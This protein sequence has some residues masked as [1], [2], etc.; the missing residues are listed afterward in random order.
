MLH[1][2]QEQRR[3]LNRLDA[4]NKI[5]EEARQT[6]QTF[7]ANVSHELRTPLN[8][9]IAYSDLITQSPHIYGR[10]PAPLLAD[11]AVIQRNGQHLSRLIDDVLD[12]SQIETGRMALSKEW[13]N[14][15][16][17]VREATETVKPLY[18]LKDLQLTFEVVD[19]LPK[20]FCDRTRIRQVLI[21][22]LS[23]AGRFTEDGGVNIRAWLA[24]SKIMI[25]ITDTGPG[26]S[27]EV[28]ENLF[29]PFQQLDSSFRRK[30]GGSGLG[31]NISKHFIEMH[32]G[33]VWLESNPGQGSTF[34]V[35]LPIDLRP[36]NP[37]ET[38]SDRRWVSPFHEYHPRTRRRVAKLPQVSPRYVVLD[39]ANTLQRLLSRYMENIDVVSTHSVP[40]A[41]E[42]LSETP[43]FAFIVNSASLQKED[44]IAAIP[45]VLPFDT[46]FVS[47]WLTSHDSIDQ[48]DIVQYIVK[49]VDNTALLSAVRAL[50]DPVRT[51][52][53]ADDEPDLLRLFTRLLTGTPEKY[54][55]IGA[56]NGSE[57]LMLLQQSQ[58]D[59]LILDLIMPNMS[60]FDLLKAKAS[61]AAIRDIPVIV[62]SSRDPNSQPVVSNQLSVSRGSGLSMRE[63]LDAIEAL[64]KVL[65][66][67]PPR[68]R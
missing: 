13:T 26:I 44:A 48:L 35:S 65:T 6:K 55:V 56:H 5:A 61:D 63:L 45:D 8:M 60:G 59:L 36:I 42:R 28:Q 68:T 3:L 1:A 46:P 18:Q 50:P 31:L 25:S 11:M 67:T 15:E 62:A 40:E 43:A 49:P 34:F 17:C 21:N 27:T 58:P 4:L 32:E 10:L 33:N 2:N 54:R 19:A 57:A 66:P 23:N 7:I 12:L 38:T 16:D 53:V 9:I 20:L 51:I 14:I 30:Y 24:D 52:L 47:C 64:T 41:I 37:I 22:L 29:E 39:Q